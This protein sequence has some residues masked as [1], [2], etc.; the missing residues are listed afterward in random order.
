MWCV[1][2]WLRYFYWGPHELVQTRGK[3]WRTPRPK[4]TGDFEAYQRA[5]REMC[6]VAKRE[7][8]RRRAA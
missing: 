4:R 5:L 7:A 6:R 1:A 2:P 8:L 3:V